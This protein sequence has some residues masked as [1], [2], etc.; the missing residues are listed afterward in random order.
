MPRDSQ[1]NVRVC[2]ILPVLSHPPDFLVNN[3]ILFWLTPTDPVIQA[4]C[5]SM[6]PASR[7][8]YSRV[9]IICPD[10]GAAVSFNAYLKN[11]NP[12]VH[13]DIHRNL[14]VRD[15]K[16]KAAGNRRD[17]CNLIFGSCEEGMDDIPRIFR[18]K[19]CKALVALC[20]QGKRE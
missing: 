5:F 8:D 20:I 18:S 10:T 13:R 16:G 2:S 12:S 15:I 6:T 4:L 1:G 9:F 3:C 7:K 17:S 14:P 11:I 19:I